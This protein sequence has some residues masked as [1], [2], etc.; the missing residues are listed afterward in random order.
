MTG[1][2]RTPENTVIIG[3]EVRSA[4]RARKSTRVPIAEQLGKDTGTD[5]QART[6]TRGAGVPSGQPRKRAST[7]GG[8]ST[9]PTKRPDAPVTPA[10]QKK[11]SESALVRYGKSALLF[12]LSIV[13]FII[14][15]MLLQ[16]AEPPADAPTEI[17]E[18][19]SP[20][21]STNTG[22]LR[23]QSDE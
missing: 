9:R 1:L 14:G 4:P 15:F 12:V 18:E 17:V 13:I 2:S 10:F 6:S 7:R 20:N 5:R 21:T 23:N 19:D 16:P 11:R 3:G 22:I 8:Q